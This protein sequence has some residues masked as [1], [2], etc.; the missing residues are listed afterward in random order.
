MK[1]YWFLHVM[2]ALWMSALPGCLSPRSDS[3]GIQTYQLSLDEQRGE[4]RR[5]PP[6]GPVLLVSPPQAEPGFETQRMV[7]VKRPFQIEYFAVNEWADTPVRMFAPLMIHALNHS[8]LWHAVIPLPSSIVGDYRLDTYGFL[9]QHEFIQQPSRVRILARMQ[10]VDLK[11]STIVSTRSF[12]AVENAPS[13]NAYGGVLA[14]NRAVAGVLD[15][16]VSWLHQC[17]RRSP[18]CAR[19]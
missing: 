3:P 10:L 9:L 14:A 15:Q 4:V 5:E 8:G 18:E 13:E 2:C 1:K 7:Y 19:S 11:E 16:I 17:I 6:D 12:E